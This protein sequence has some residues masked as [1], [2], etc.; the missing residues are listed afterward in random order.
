MF[1]PGRGFHISNLRF[2]NRTD[3]TNESDGELACAKAFFVWLNMRAVTV[4]IFWREGINEKMANPSLAAL[5]VKPLA[6][7]A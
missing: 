3:G 6:C 5:A 7:P 1:A 4:V 2:Q